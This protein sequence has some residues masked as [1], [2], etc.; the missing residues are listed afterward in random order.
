MMLLLSSSITTI[1]SNNMEIYAILVMFAVIFYTL[2]YTI[3][4]IIRS[5]HIE[6]IG[7]EG[8]LDIVNIVGTIVF[9]IILVSI[10][11]SFSPSVIGIDLSN[12]KN[13]YVLYLSGVDS[14]TPIIEIAEGYLNV[15]YFET[16]E[17]YRMLIS[18]NMIV[19]AF[20]SA[21]MRAGI[22]SI[23]PFAG[24]DVI[25][26]IV[27]YLTSTVIVFLITTVTQ[28][29]LLK[30]F[31]VTALSLFVP[32]GIGLRIFPPTKSVGN[33]IIALALTMYFMYP[34]LM[35]FNFYILANNSSIDIST[36]TK[37]TYNIDQCESDE[38]C[39]SGVCEKI[40]DQNNKIIKVC[41]PCILEGQAKDPKSCCAQSTYKDGECTIDDTGLTDDKKK[42][43]M[44]K[45]GGIIVDGGTPGLS[46]SKTIEII[47]GAFT[48]MRMTPIGIIKGAAGSMI[49][50]IASIMGIGLA[51]VTALG[52]VGVLTNPIVI[53]A[54]AIIINTD[55]MFFGL[56]LPIIE[57][58]ILV[59]FL[60]VITGALGSTI[61]LIQVYRVL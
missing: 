1:I 32:L 53:I 27:P 5:M 52:L 60:R 38:E 31:K 61:D 3:G 23:S 9:V 33:S 7:K 48:L 41:Q 20:A 57:F 19:K 34:L 18:T 24:Y 22:D 40:T 37:Y 45:K 39:A 15:L 28:M 36:I 49:S 54:T 51:I 11:N 47:V 25:F 12:A 29:A 26:S 8:L 55:L 56:L 16:E 13:A 43:L 2:V 10:I 35:T 4:R 17:F 50:A 44:K 6:S 46:L 30:F 14:N 42:E 59:E 58:I 21:S